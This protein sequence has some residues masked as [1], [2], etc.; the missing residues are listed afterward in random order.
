[1]PCTGIALI[2]KRPVS[3]TSQLEREVDHL[4]NDA[5]KPFHLLIETAIVKHRFQQAEILPHANE[6]RSSAETRC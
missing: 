5:F 6:G 3:L 4:R 1:M 2:E